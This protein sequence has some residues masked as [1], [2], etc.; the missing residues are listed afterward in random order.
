[1]ANFR[2]NNGYS[3]YSKL[4]LRE[5]EEKQDAKASMLEY[6]KEKSQAIDRTIITHEGLPSYSE[7][8]LTLL[9]GEVNTYKLNEPLEAGVFKNFD[10]ESK[11]RYLQLLEKYYGEITLGSTA[12]MLHID[13]KEIK[14]LFDKA[15][16]KRFVRGQRADYNS[17][18]RFKQDMGL[19]EYE[20]DEVQPTKPV[21]E[22]K[23]VAVKVCEP[24]PPQP[25]PIKKEVP[26]VNLSYL[27]LDCEAE[28][29]L[30]ALSTLPL[31]GR[32]RVTI[33]NSFVCQEEE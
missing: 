1:M 26:P 5:A 13:H 24:E 22:V 27:V 21:D 7:A 29:L 14:N 19:W 2:A 11:I 32:Y 16:I 9:S 23:N 6:N 20:P 25:E 3:P 30:L 4:K 28:D 10:Y 33:T 15:G 12:A 8:E 18:K 17:M 31:R